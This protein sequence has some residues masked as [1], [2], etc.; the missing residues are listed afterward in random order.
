VIFLNPASA[1]PS[2]H[3]N[4]SGSNF[5]PSA[6]LN[7]L[8]DGTEISTVKSDAGG[9]IPVTAIV[10]PDNAAVASHQVCVEFTQGVNVCAAFTLEPPVS[11]SPSPAASPSPSPSASPTSTPAPVATSTGGVSPLAVMTRPP[12]VFLPIVAVVGLIL[13]LSLWAWLSR[14]GPPLGEVTVHHL[15][16]S[17]RSYESTPLAPPAA[18][19]PRPEPIVYESP[20]S[21]PPPSAAPPPPPPSGADVPPDLPEASD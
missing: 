17:P 1:P 3:V 19:E 7:V 8:F 21:S 12:F 9:S 11:P 18:P 6:T 16:P 14:P 10:I 15:A 2:T 4:L 13:F 20:E 5:P